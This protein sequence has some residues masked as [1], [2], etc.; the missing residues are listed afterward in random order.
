MT[1]DGNFRERADPRDGWRIHSLLT[2]GLLAGALICNSLDLLTTWHI[3]SR[4]QGVELNSLLA[5]ILS[6]YGFV[7]VAIYKG[8]AM[9]GLLVLLY[10]CCTKD[11]RWRGFSLLVLATVTILLSGVVA[12]NGLQILRI[13]GLRF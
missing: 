10:L 11:W 12:W 5:A 13:A 6:Q 8:V 3:Y 7:A 1:G 4:F 9:S 2:A